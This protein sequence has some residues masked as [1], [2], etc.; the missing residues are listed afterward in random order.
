MPRAPKHNFTRCL[1][2]VFA[3]LLSVAFVVE[4][5]FRLID[6]TIRQPDHELYWLVSKHC[7]TQSPCEFGLTEVV[8][9]VWEKAAFIDHMCD[10]S[11]ASKLLGVAA[12]K[13]PVL[14]DAAFVIVHNGEPILID[15][16]LVDPDILGNIVWIMLSEATCP[17]NNLHLQ[18]S[19]PGTQTTETVPCISIRRVF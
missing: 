8:G 5:T 4:L 13:F 15:R 19:A 12:H 11:R 16:I 18:H 17:Y 14:P 7:N 1:S 9:F 6:P 2:A 3:L 10:H